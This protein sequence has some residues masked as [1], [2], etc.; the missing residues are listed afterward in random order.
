MNFS[1]TFEDLMN[2]G[3]KLNISSDRIQK[4]DDSNQS[5]GNTAE[6]KISFTKLDLNKT[7]MA[8]QRKT[9]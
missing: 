7:N 8:F 9:R 4:R 3:L 1:R 2:T 5:L 6:D